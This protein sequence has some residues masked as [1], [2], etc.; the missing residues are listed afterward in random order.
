MSF[1]AIREN[2]IL[3]KIFESTVFGKLSMYTPDCGDEEKKALER[4]VIIMYDR[5][6]TATDIDS[7]RLD[8]F[9]S[10]T[11]RSRQAVP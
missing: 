7:V 2:K 11:Y 10:P 9:F 4:F 5:S 3:A 8:M 6:S 1:H